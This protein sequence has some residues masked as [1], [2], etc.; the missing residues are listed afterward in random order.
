MIQPPRPSSQTRVRMRAISARQSRIREDRVATEEPLEIRIDLGGDVRSAAV[1]MRTP[2]ADFELATGF[3]LAEGIIRER[4]DVRQ[5]SYCVDPGLTAEQRYNVVTVRLAGN[6]PVDFDPLNRHFLISSACGVC[7]KTSLDQLELQ[8]AVP[9]PDGPVV[10]VSV[11]TGLPDALRSRQRLFDSTGG[12]HAAA[13]FDAD[14]SLMAVREDIG[15]HNALDKLLGWAMLDGR[16]PA[17]RGMVLVSGRAS[18]ELA[19]KCVAAGVPILCAVSA[20]SSLAIDVARRFNLTLVGFLREDRCNVYHGS[21]RIQV[22][23]A[24]LERRNRTG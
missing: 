24:D 20:P 21:H 13:L 15:R 8:G 17:H 1:T 10:P 2:G 4:E 23:E 11:L 5:I 6:R 9:L 19:Q 7:G 18:F 3:L 14:G 16:L 22:G 12:L